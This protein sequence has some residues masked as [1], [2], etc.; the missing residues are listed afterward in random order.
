[1]INSLLQKDYNKRMGINILYNIIL[2][3]IKN[4]NINYKN[5]IIG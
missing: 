3:E 4:I 5:I 1:M 2:N